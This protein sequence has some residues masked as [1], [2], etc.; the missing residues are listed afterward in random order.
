MFLRLFQAVREQCLHFQDLAVWL[1]EDGSV[2]TGNQSCLKGVLDQDPGF[3]CLGLLNGC[4]GWRNVCLGWLTGWLGD[5]PADW[6]T[7]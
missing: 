5:W 7:V 1:T 2:I 3:F 4:L 6:L